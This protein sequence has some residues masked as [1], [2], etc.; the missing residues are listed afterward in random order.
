[1][2]VLH[3]PTSTGGN[4]QGLSKALR[5]IGIEST[6]LVLSQN[7]L[8]YTSDIT[9]HK[10]PQ[11]L[12]IRELMRLY[13]IFIILPK[14]DIIHYNSGTTIST[15]YGIEL[16]SYID[17]KAWVRYLYSKYLQLLQQIEI[18]YLKILKKRIF[19]TFQG[20]D[21]RQGDY[22]RKNFSISIANQVNPGYY[23]PAS[24][25]FKRYAIARFEKIATCIYSVNPDLMHVLPSRTKFSAYC[26]IFLDEWIPNYPSTVSDKPI[27]IL[28]APSH[29]K[30][31]G[32]EQIL[33]V[34]ETLKQNGYAFE[35]ILVEGMSNAEAKKVYEHADLLIDQ[36][37]AG[38]YG[39]LAVELMALGKPVMCYLRDEDL[40]YIPQQMKL[41]LPIINVSEET[42]YSEVQKFLQMSR[43]EIHDLGK[44]SRQYVEKWHDPIKIATEIAGDY[45]QSMQFN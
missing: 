10:P 1:M 9:L 24:D 14:F 22:C 44:K 40:Q 42:L 33:S 30:A 17:A 29:R 20:D 15:A 23:T 27:K 39:G 8:G 4:P 3:A 25:I 2:R 5:K 38:W 35:L 11:P 18:F 12:L 6:S 21:A 43:G 7:Y 37:F 41:D 28:H 19:F 13:A 16:K 32:T 45:I 34:L 31:K 36:I 26:H